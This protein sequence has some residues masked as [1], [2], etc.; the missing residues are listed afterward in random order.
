MSRKTKELECDQYEEEFVRAVA[1]AEE[2]FKLKKYPRKLLPETP[3]RR[4]TSIQ[5]NILEWGLLRALYLICMKCRRPTTRRAAK[6]L[7]FWTDLREG[8]LE[9]SMLVQYARAVI[10]LEEG[11]NGG[12]LDEG[13]ALPGLS[14]DFCSL[15]ENARFADVAA[16]DLLPNTEKFQLVCGRFMHESQGQ[17]QLITYTCQSTTAWDMSS[18]RNTSIKKESVVEIPLLRNSMPS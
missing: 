3:G 4:S 7:L 15:P 12:F 2:Y 6:R 11:R 13:S 5:S 10:A 16:V 1:R 14:T 17:V 8:P 18:W 9:S